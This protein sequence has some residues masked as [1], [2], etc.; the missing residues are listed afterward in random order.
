MTRGSTV[1]EI[2]RVDGENSP[3]GL[4]HMA[5]DDSLGGGRCDHGLSPFCLLN[6]EAGQVWRA[7][8]LPSHTTVVRFVTD[9]PER[10]VRTAQ[11]TT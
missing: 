2:W 5:T 11:P 8:C 3:F 4:M 7:C 9:D 1:G 6:C 10:S